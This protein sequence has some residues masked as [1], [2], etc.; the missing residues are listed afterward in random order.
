MSGNRIYLQSLRQE[1]PLASKYDEY[2]ELAGEAFVRANRETDP[3]KASH[4]RAKAYEYIALRDWHQNT[5]P[6]KAPV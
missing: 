3:E 2:A 6:V 5:K 4:Y 1:S